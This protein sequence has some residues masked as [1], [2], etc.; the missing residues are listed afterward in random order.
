MKTNTRKILLFCVKIDMLIVDFP[1]FSKLVL[2]G[3]LF[4]NVNT[5]NHTAKS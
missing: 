1:D 2:A 5:C 3:R 4:E